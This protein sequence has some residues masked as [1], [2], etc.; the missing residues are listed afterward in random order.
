MGTPQKVQ[1]L[2]GELMNCICQQD[3]D[4]NV[5]EPCVAHADLAR[6]VAAKE[7]CRLAEEIRVDGVDIHA[8]AE[9]LEDRA[10]GVK[11]LGGVKKKESIK[12]G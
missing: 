2:E 7:L 11:A 3:K 9:I 5:I 8:V 4:E 10:A 1:S 6:A 12:T